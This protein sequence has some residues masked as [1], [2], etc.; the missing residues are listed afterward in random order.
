MDVKRDFTGFKAWSA[1]IQHAGQRLSDVGIRLD[2]TLH[3]PNGYDEAIVRDALETRY[4]AYVERRRVRGDRMSGNRPGIWKYIRHAEQFL[5]KVGIQADGSLYNPNGYDEAVVR[6]AIRQA[7]ERRHARRSAVAKK[8]A[9]TRQQRQ[10][11]RVYETAQG[12]LARKQYGPRNTCIICGKPVWDG[13][14][15]ERGIG[16][17]CWQNVLESIS[18]QRAERAAA[19]A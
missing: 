2:G 18:R 11:K 4:R 7:N 15:V 19:V 14:S 6:E 10:E 1:S 17:D 3:N 5:Y 8:A 12:I 9:V 16:S 13:E